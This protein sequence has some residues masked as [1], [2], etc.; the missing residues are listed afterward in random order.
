MASRLSRGHSRRSEPRPLVA[1]CRWKA[2]MSAPHCQ[3]APPSLLTI[4]SISYITGLD[5]VQGMN[6]FN[7]KMWFS[8]QAGSN[9]CVTSPQSKAVSHAILLSGLIEKTAWW[10][11]CE[12]IKGIL[13]NI[14]SIKRHTHTPNW[15][16]CLCHFVSTPVQ[17]S[18][19]SLEWKVWNP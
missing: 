11:K 19:R 2:V 3:K 13:W 17:N 14:K 4:L 8:D 12:E 1:F 5:G 7:K 16:V 15:S 18:V 6:F 10:V 9:E